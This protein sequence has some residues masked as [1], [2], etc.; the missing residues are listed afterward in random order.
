MNGTENENIYTALK[1]EEGFWSIDEGGVRSFLI[2]GIDRAMLVDTGFGHGDLKA[3]VE[4]LT[5]HPIFLVNT[6]TD[7]DHIGCNEQFKRAFMH[8]SEMDYYHLRNGNDGAEALPVLDGHVFDLRIRKF[9]VI[10]IPGHTPGSIA[11]LD[12]SN[13]LLISGDSISLGGIFM[14][15]SGRDMEAYISSMQKLENMLDEFD[16]IWPSHGLGPIDSSIIA[17][18]IEGA[19]KLLRGELE[20]KIPGRDL[21]CRL[22]EY[23]R[24][25]FLY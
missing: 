19:K 20:G 2:E 7:G 5:P 6:H 14:F 24:A 13:K 3:F 25:H 16:T 18:L 10:A 9:E 17:E 22:F 1:L 21:P 15:G 11:L 4:T 23:G 12:R 8:P